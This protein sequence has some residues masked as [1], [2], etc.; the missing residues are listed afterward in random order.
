MWTA[1]EGSGSIAAWRDWPAA[2]PGQVGTVLPLSLGNA[3]HRVTLAHIE[4]SFLHP[5]LGAPAVHACPEQP[6]KPCNPL[7][8][9]CATR[10]GSGVGVVP[11]GKSSRKVNPGRPFLHKDTLS[12]VFT[13]Q[14]RWHDSLISLRET[15]LEIPKKTHFGP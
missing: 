13:A 3:E 10:Y 7:H 5:D 8:A 6:E 11:L 4:K 14:T 2:G 12:L 1:L 15:S 9:F